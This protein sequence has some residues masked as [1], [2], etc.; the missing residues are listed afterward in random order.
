MTEDIRPPPLTPVEEAAMDPRARFRLIEQRHQQ[1]F[2]SHSGGPEAVLAAYHYATMYFLRDTGF[3]LAELKR[4]WQALDLKAPAGSREAPSAPVY[5]QGPVPVLP[6]RPHQ[7]S[8]PVPTMKRPVSGPTPPPPRY[9]PPLPV[10]SELISRISQAVAR[11]ITGHRQI[12]SDDVDELFRELQ[13]PDPSDV[14]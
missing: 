4:A 7:P 3:L 5:V 9:P 1:V 8:Q 10:D 12:E 13:G 14:E 2:R 6:P 11:E